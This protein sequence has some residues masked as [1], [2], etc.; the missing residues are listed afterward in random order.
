KAPITHSGRRRNW[1]A[2]HTRLVISTP[3][4]MGESPFQYEE[5]GHDGQQDAAQRAAG[6]WRFG[7]LVGCERLRRHRVETRLDV[8]LLPIVEQRTRG[9]RVAWRP[10]CIMPQAAAR[11]VGVTQTV[12]RARLGQLGESGW[13]SYPPQ[14]CAQRG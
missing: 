10:I 1:A 11:T 14:R 3:P 5:C 7:A 4:C 6:R 12:Q 9:L 2:R 8:Q 13:L